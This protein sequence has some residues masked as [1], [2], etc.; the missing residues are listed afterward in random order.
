MSI[1]F[2]LEK[3]K[4]HS[5]QPAIIWNNETLTY[6][7]LIK[8]YEEAENFISENNILPGQ[9]TALTGDFTPNTIALLLALISNQNIIVPLNAPIKESELKK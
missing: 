3:F 2:L 4:E 5:K 8:K 1:D 7:D 9:V 6:L